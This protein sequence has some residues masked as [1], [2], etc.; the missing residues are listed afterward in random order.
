LGVNETTCSGLLGGHHQALQNSKRLNIFCVWR[1]LRS[2]HL[3][4][5]LYTRQNACEQVRRS[6][7]VGMWY[8]FTSLLHTQ[9]GCLN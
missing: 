2:H 3:A 8:P 5:K 6:T 7:C 9:W 4:Y 1:M